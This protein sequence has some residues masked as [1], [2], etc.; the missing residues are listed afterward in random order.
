MNCF[1]VAHWVLLIFH[2]RTDDSTYLA[3]FRMQ[4]VRISAK[5]SLIPSVC[6]TLE[7]KATR[8]DVHIITDVHWWAVLLRSAGLYDREVA[9]LSRSRS[10]KGTVFIQPRRSWRD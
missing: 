4:A 10:R 3:C 2:E 9:G 7:S 1:N 5:L 8:A 6:G